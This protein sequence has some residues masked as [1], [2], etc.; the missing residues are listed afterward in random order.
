[1][2]ERPIKSRVVTMKVQFSVM[3]EGEYSYSH[4]LNISIEAEPLPDEV[5]PVGYIARRLSEEL[6]RQAP[7]VRAK[8]PQVAGDEV[9]V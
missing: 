7:L 3:R 5:D 1:M 6:R 2:D 8:S 9:A 4:P